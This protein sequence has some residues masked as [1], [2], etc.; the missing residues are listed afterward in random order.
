MGRFDEDEERKRKLAEEAQKSFIEYQKMLK[1]QMESMKNNPMF[2]MN[3][4]IRHDITLHLTMYEIMCVAD[5][6]YTHGIALNMFPVAQEP[7]SVSHN[8]EHDVEMTTIKKTVAEVIDGHLM[9]MIDDCMADLT[10]FTDEELKKH[11]LEKHNLK[12]RNINMV[13]KEEEPS[14]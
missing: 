8:P 9:C 14:G 2:N 1:D 11:F 4:E 13:K 10:G 3:P 12:V 6:C 7:S 5:Y